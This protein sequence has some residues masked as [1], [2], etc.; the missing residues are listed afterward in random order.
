MTED[1]FTAAPPE[2]PTFLTV[3]CILTFIGSGFGVLDRITKL[4]HISPWLS[5]PGAAKYNSPLVSIIALIAAILCLA[6]AI[7]MWKLYRHGYILYVIGAVISIIASVAAVTIMGPEIKSTISQNLNASN[8]TT[9]I[10]NGMAIV[11]T[12]AL[13]FSVAES[14]V[15]NALF[16]ILYG[17]NRKYLVK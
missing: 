11:T 10:A 5:L 14:I 12:F 15:I 4:C 13:W 6:G 7:R 8:Q 1:T 9:Q 17:V 2:R 16:I 3:L